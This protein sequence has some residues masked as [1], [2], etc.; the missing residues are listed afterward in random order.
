MST[1]SGSFENGS[2]YTIKTTSGELSGVVTESGPDGVT[3]GPE[4]KRIL[5]KDILCFEKVEV[6]AKGG[7]QTAN[8]ILAS[9]KPFRR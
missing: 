5:L 9:G 3:V 1:N 6:Q 4:S 8:A 2:L 7:A